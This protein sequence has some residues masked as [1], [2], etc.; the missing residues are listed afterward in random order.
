MGR[1]GPAPKPTVIEI[2][3]G[4]PRKQKI[5]LR[6]PMPAHITREETR[7]PPAHLSAT[8]KVW[9]VYYADILRSLKVLT[10]ADLMALENLATA[11]V[12]RINYEAQ[13][14]KTGPLYKTST[15][16]VMVSPMFSIVDRLKAREFQ[17]L[18]EFGM[19]PSSRTRVQ[20]TQPDD[21][22]NAIDDAMYG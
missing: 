11:T 21:G 3:E 15:G 5:N 20:I 18:R 13:L 2:A 1:R 8:A 22:R 4:R 19:T 9:W 16:Y 12:D 17:L 10:E 7:T 6:E 14:A